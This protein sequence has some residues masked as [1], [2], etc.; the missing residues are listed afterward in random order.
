MRELDFEKQEYDDIF[1]NGN[2]SM[3]SVK[4]PSRMEEGVGDRKVLELSL[5]VKFIGHGCP[6]KRNGI[7]K[8]V[9]NHIEQI[10]SFMWQR[11]YNFK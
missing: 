5:S 4:F 7:K 3:Y 6:I 8:S 2:A 10:P 1:K 11:H 9:K